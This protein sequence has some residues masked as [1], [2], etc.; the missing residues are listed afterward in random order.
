MPYALPKCS[1]RTERCI[2]RCWNPCSIDLLHLLW[3]NSKYFI[4]VASTSVETSLKATEEVVRFSDIVELVGDDTFQKLYNA[5]WLGRSNLI[6]WFP[7]FKRWRDDGNSPDPWTICEVEWCMNM[8]SSSWGAKRWSDLRNVNGMSS[9]P[10]VAFCFIFWIADSS[11][12]IFMEVQF[13]LPTDG[14]LSIF[15]E[16][17]WN[18]GSLLS[19]G[20]CWPWHNGWC[21]C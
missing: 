12:D 3:H 21:R 20:A 15:W 17:G 1:F 11:L 6:W 5:A 4:L 9:G 7:R 19:C 8:E 10:A 16:D 14:V 18:H 2:R 13:S